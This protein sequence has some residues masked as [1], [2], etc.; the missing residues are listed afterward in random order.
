MQDGG[1]RCWGLIYVNEQGTL[2]TR[3]NQT[4]AQ[5]IALQ[6]GVTAVGIA[7][8]GLGTHW[9]AVADAGLQCLGNNSFDQLGN[10]T[11]ISRALPTQ[12]LP[13]GAG[14]TAVSMGGNDA[15]VEPSIAPVTNSPPRVYY[16][17]FYTFAVVNGGA[18]CW[19]HNMLGQLG[20]ASSGPT[21][22][23]K[24]MVRLS[25]AIIKGSPNAFTI[26]TVDNTP[27]AVDISSEAFTVSGFEG[28]LPISIE[29]GSYLLDCNEDNRMFGNYTTAPSRVASGTSVCVRT[30]SASNN[31]DETHAT[32]TVGEPSGITASAV[33][34]V[35]TFDPQPVNCYLVTFPRAGVTSSF[36]RQF[37]TLDESRYLE[38]TT[39]TNSLYTGQGVAHKVYA[40]KIVKN[41][42]AAAPMYRL[43]IKPTDAYFWTTDENKYQVVRQQSAIFIDE[44]IECYVFLREW[45]VGTIPLFRMIEQHTFTHY[46][47]TDLSAIQYAPI[48]GRTPEGLQGNALGA[49]GYLWPK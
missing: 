8:E 35:R 4:P 25:G 17:G 23:E 31:G 2:G 37:F 43:F 49:V 22:G 40:E 15:I 18:V 27:L 5:I 7:G 1:L 13:S 21:V 16:G 24:T 28:L 34:K 9:C 46:W 19:G 30:R 29:D 39:S 33:F 41:G 44:G 20:V 10:G 26:A 48:S 14:V 47:T 12:I 6:R 38:L 42:Q 45:A 3:G 36:K 11:T 32:L